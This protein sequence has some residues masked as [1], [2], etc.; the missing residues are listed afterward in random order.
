MYKDVTFAL[1]RRN[2]RRE[3]EEYSRGV[4]MVAGMTG[5]DMGCK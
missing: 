2:I 3:F 1:H 5:A 4:L